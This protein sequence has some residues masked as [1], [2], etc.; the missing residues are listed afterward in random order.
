M[1]KHYSLDEKLSAFKLDV[2][3]GKENAKQILYEWF[4]EW[5]LGERWF[6]FGALHSCTDT[7]C[8]TG[9]TL[10]EI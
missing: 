9:S 4:S 1:I 7:V 10:S 5:I 3:S 8:E 2:A 6:Y